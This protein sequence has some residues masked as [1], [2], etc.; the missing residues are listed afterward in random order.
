MESRTKTYTVSQVNALVKAAIS[1]R[2]P[3]RF[4]VRAQIRDWKHHSSGHCYFSL[5]DDR[6]VLTAVMWKS[7]FARVKFEPENGMEILATGNVDVYVPG[8]KYQ[9]YAEKLE[10]LGVGGLQV[11]YDQMVAKL[12]A[13]GLFDED[14]KKPLP[15]Y[16]ERIGILTSQTGAAI[17]DVADSIFER[18]PLAEL[19]LFP[20]PVQGENAALQIAKTLTQVNQANK[21]YGL[22]LLI[23]GRG[24]GSL[25]DLWAF[26][27]E[28]LARAIFASTIPV[29]SAVGH[30]VDVTVADFVAD[31]RASTPTKA[32]VTAVPDQAEILDQLNHCQKRL[33]SHVNNSVALSRA[34]LETVSAA[35]MFKR[36]QAV[37]QT[38]TQQVDE[39]L[40]LLERCMADRLHC[41]LRTVG[42]CYDVVLRLEPHR[43]L[44]KRTHELDQLAGRVVAAVARHMYECTIQLEQRAAH[45][46]G[47]NPK[48]V[49]E[50]GYSMTSHADTGQVIHSV[51]DVTPGDALIT[52]LAGDQKIYSQVTKTQSSPK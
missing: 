14:H 49:L 47:L 40:S 44:G 32:G 19:L 24:G 16:P 51:Q 25:E 36:P 50:R 31:A 42:H 43:L 39:S 3:A 9:F 5:K 2:L 21:Q 8:G 27:E 22:D 18:W 37:L 48:S 29:I 4:I 34:R 41:Q 23:V 28:I 6:G 15:Q 10:P 33:A 38:K 7:Q 45:L 30:E 20:V 11:A 12:R 46:S 35:D 52:E 13:E 1:D 17:H 26:N